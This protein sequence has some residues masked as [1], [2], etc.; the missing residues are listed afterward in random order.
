MKFLILRHTETVDCAVE[1]L[2]KYKWYW[3]VANRLLRVNGQVT[4]YGEME[5]HIARLERDIKRLGLQLHSMG[6]GWMFEKPGVS[7]RALVEQQ[8]ACARL[9][10]AEKEVLALVN[11]KRNLL[12]F[13][14]NARSRIGM[15]L[16]SYFA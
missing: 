14:R 16:P 3:H 5:G 9:T 4:D 10:D 8:A 7:E 6:H 1:E 15:K 2:M 13:I 11:G 12:L